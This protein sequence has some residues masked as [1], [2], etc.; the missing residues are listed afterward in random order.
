M[1]E[2]ENNTDYKPEE[3]L[4]KAPTVIDAMPSSECAQLS[5]SERTWEALIAWLYN[6]YLEELG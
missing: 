5:E 6:K 2:V 4:S 3:I 1:Q